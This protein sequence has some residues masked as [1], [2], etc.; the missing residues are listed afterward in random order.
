MSATIPGWTPE[1]ERS[2]K[3]VLFRFLEEVQST[4]AALYLLEP[5][6]SYALA[7]N[8]G[9]R[10][11]DLLAQTHLQKDPLV[12]RTLHAGGSV[13]VINEI[14]SEPEIASYVEGAGT[15]RLLVAPLIIEDR[16]LGF[17]DARDKGRKRPFDD[18]DIH[19]A[20][21]IADAIIDLARRSSLYPGLK[22]AGVQ[23]L[24]SVEKPP[25]EVAEPVLIDRRM[26]QPEQSSVIALMD[27]CALDQLAHATLQAAHRN[28]I[29]AVALTLTEDLSGAT[30]LFAGKLSGEIDSAALVRHQSEALQQRGFVAPHPRS[31]RLEVFRLSDVG[32]PAPS[33]LVASDV[34]LTTQGCSIIASVVGIMGSSAAAECLEHLK[35]TAEKTGNLV[36]LRFARRFLARRVLE[37]ADGAYPE[38]IEHSISV[39]RLAWTIACQLNMDKTETEE[40]A[41]AGLLHDVGMRELEYDRI[42]RLQNPGSEERALYREHPVVG[43]SIV[44]G[45]GFEAI[46]AAVR[47][48]HERWDGKGYPDRLAGTTI[49]LLARIVHVAEVFDVLTSPG[50]YRRAMAP[51]KAILTMKEAAG[52]Q[53]DPDLITI[54]SRIAE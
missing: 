29:V 47:H 43:E 53:L 34:L 48:H 8:Y 5:E 4:K 40:A 16:L 14:R 7:T 37:P 12:T 17:V 52:T 50:S 35:E 31:W 27:V 49:P 30:L 36:E 23:Q 33:R 39:S 42:Y 9:F 21:N 3:E 28:G 11:R 41:L 15:Q 32:D 26:D 25:S 54:M 10:G 13:L 20:S 2:F 1:L 44:S 18:A 46:A 38:L 45:A 24:A 19:R 51:D 6:G 22:K